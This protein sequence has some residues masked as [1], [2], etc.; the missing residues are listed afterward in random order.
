MFKFAFA[1]GIV[2]EWI[3][4]PVI[5][6]APAFGMAASRAFIAT[7]LAWIALEALRAVVRAVQ[8]LDD[9]TSSTTRP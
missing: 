4:G 8:T 3:A 2:A 6:S 9:R 1:L 7:L 5:A